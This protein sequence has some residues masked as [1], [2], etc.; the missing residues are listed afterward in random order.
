MVAHI[1][2]LVNT[3]VINLIASG[4]FITK[5]QEA[6]AIYLFIPSMS[7]NGGLFFVFVVTSS[8]TN[9]ICF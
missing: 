4:R 6:G 8:C 9:Q 2:L 1:H 3:H 7:K 5:V